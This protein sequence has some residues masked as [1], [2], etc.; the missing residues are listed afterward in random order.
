MPLSMSMGMSR[1]GRGNV[2]LT[3]AASSM[4]RSAVRRAN[5]QDFVAIDAS[6]PTQSMLASLEARVADMQARA[7]ALPPPGAGPLACATPARARDARWGA[8]GGAEPRR[9]LRPS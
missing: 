3:R 9:L 5:S 7:P 4:G 8:G 6:D 2:P 1:D